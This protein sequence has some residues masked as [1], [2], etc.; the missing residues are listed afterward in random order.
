MTTKKE[1]LEFLK[2]KLNEFEIKKKLIE[3]LLDSTDANIAYFEKEMAL[4]SKHLTKK[5]NKLAILKNQLIY[6]KL[7][8]DIH[9]ECIACIKLILIIL[10]QKYNAGICN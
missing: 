2:D 5:K 6:I 8:L 7:S 1:T 10:T 3:D 4:S 9:K